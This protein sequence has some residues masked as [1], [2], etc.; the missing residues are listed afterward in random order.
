L[1]TLTGPGGRGKTR[2]ALRVARD[3]HTEHEDR[4]WLTEFVPSAEAEQAAL[5]RLPVFAAGT[6]RAQFS[7]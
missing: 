4:I 5:Q 7:F 3:L 2:L 6:A 1:L